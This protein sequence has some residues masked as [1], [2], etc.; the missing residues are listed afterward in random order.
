MD[1][2]LR[3][4]MLLE[5]GD[6]VTKPLRDIAGGSTRAAQALKATR[7]R[8][9]EIQRA[10]AS[11]AGFRELKTGL[12]TTSASLKAAEGRVAALARQMA[13]AAS[14]SKKLAA[15]FAKA[16]REA[17]G[18]RTTFEQQSAELQK[19]R[20]RL[21][22][23]GVSTRSLVGHERQLREAA[24]RANSELAEQEQRL[25]RL[26]ERSRRFA[27]ARESFGRT[28]G[29]ATGLA[30][31]GASS[32]GVGMTIARPLVDGVEKSAAFESS[33]TTIGQKASLARTQVNALG[34]QVLNLA[35]ATNQLPEE[36]QKGTDALAGFG[37]DPNQAIKMMTPIGRAATAYKAENED[38]AA[39]SYAAYSNL[40]VPIEQT[41]LAIDTMA[42]AGK[43]GAFELK[44]MAQY[45]PALTAG[46][47]AL[48]QTGIGAVADLGAA[49]QVIR[50]GTG[51]SASAGVDLENI[52]QKLASPATIKAFQKMGVDL[53]AALK[54]AYAEGKTPLEALAELTNKTL[55]GDLGKLGFLFEDAQVQQGLRPLIQNLQEYRSIRADAAKAGGTT[56]ADFAER[57]KDTAERTK[58]LTINAQALSVTLGGQLQPTVNSLSDR[59][60]TMA[61]RVNDWAQRH[62]TLT[63]T[64]LLSAAGLAALFVVL[65]IGGILIAAIMGPIAILNAGL[66]AVGVSGG[67]ASIG[68]L[69]IIGTIAAIVV[70]LALLAGAAYLIISNWDSIT[71]FFAG[72][73][74]TI[75]AGF[76]GG[77]AGITA[78]LINFSPVGLLYAGFAALLRWL[79][80]D[81]PANLSTV[82]ANIIHGLVSGIKGALKFLYDAVTGA[83]SSAAKWFKEKLGIHSPSRVFMAFGGHIMTGLS[84]GIAGGEDGPVR[85]IDR[86]S[87]RLTT[88]MAVGVSLPALAAPSYAQSAAQSAAGVSGGAA[89]GRHYEIHV[90]AA[91][92]MDEKKLADLVA[93]KIDEADRGKSA[94]RRASFADDPDWSHSA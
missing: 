71:G 39:A 3:I 55:K 75:K 93:R 84:N 38:L 62:P 73:W 59:I 90:Y 88:A 91:P 52:L 5:A 61:D 6:R 57:M 44:D 65:G 53:P 83:A 17:S 63:K 58:R 29:M 9:K 47:Q 4:R 80:V 21:A 25:T 82:G 22:A 30:A 49:L 36:I 74:N 56:D 37:L 51:D 24:A 2:N 1:R 94:T 69:P 26:T 60:S 16:K 72:I 23:A 40:K 68:L 78:L 43:R 54:K 67:I 34:V 50:K 8:L 46:Y 79:G 76:H 64:I 81:I 7:D 70:G 19:I 27:A 12:Q 42:Y 45:M 11:I 31:G 20:D 32:I 41:A 33:M 48:G 35:R 92:G 86:L 89:G 10:Q 15:D 66:I 85:R 87:R 14:P 28:Q 77:I 13:D 18:L